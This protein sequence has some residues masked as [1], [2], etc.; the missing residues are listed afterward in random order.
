MNCNYAVQLG[1]QAGFSLVG[2]A[3]SDLRN[4]CQTATLALLWQLM[5]AYTLAIL[6]RLAAATAG[7]TSPM[8]SGLVVGSGDKN[9]NSLN[10]NNN[11]V[12]GQTCLTGSSWRPRR[13]GLDQKG[14]A[15]DR[16]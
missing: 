16:L 7:A 8:D 6:T 14:D 9:N 3:G 15:N 1:L 4:G 2:L 11:A 12:V 10:T 5:R 13:G